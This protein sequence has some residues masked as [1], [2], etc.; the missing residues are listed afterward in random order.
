M[1][2]PVTV[3]PALTLTLSTE[4][5]PKSTEASVPLAGTVTVHVVALPA[6]AH[7]VPPQPLIFELV[8]GR[9]VRI[10]DESAAKS[11]A[12]AGG[13][14]IPAGWLVTRPVPPA[15]FTVTVRRP[16]TLGMLVTLMVIDAAAVWPPGNLAW[17][18]KL[19]VPSPK[20]HSPPIGCGPVS[21]T[22]RRLISSPVRGA[23]LET[24]MRTVTAGG[25]GEGDRV[26]DGV[27]AGV[28][29]VV[30]WRVGGCWGTLGPGPDV[31]GGGA[32]GPEGCVVGPL[33]GCFGSYL[34]T[35][36]TPP[37]NRITPACSLSGSLKNTTPSR[38]TSWN[39]VCGS[40]TRGSATTR[41]WS[42]ST[43]Q[44]RPAS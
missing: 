40:S 42:R 15:L 44:T 13:Q 10:T 24:T 8:P 21:L 37:S 6:V 25:L 39:R 43:T 31:V 4:L 20:L 23:S 11:K 2:P 19:N 36:R 5:N 38:L 28:G 27:G 18:P 34:A 16:V 30:G 29:E 3:P 7:P 33:V 41:S 32:V 26:G 1:P 35:G 14:L 9:A 12:Q 17:T 22:A